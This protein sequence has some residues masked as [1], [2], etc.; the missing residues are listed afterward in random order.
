[1][2]HPPVLLLL[3]LT[4]I[5]AWRLGSVASF[6]VM[7]PMRPWQSRHNLLGT[8]LEMSAKA[9]TTVKQR[10]VF[11]THERD[12]FRQDARLNSMESYVLVSALTTSMSFGCLVGFCPHLPLSASHV[13][14]RFLFVAIQVVSGLSSLFGLYATTIFALTILYGKSALGAERDREYDMFLRRTIRARVN[15]ARCFSYSL[16]SFAMLNVLILVERTYPRRLIS[17]PVGVAVAVLL[18]HLY[19]DWRLLVQS[20]E[21]I[22]KD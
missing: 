20:K 11:L 15:A 6:T 1:M 7:T 3:L 18:F 2:R 14:Y 12:F 17:G 4:T 9:P 8:A 19:R 13:L 21:I 5:M 16:A 10:P 22:Y